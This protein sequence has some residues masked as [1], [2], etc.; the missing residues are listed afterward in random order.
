MADTGARPLVLLDV[1]GPLN[2]YAAK[3]EKRP[4]GYTTHW[5]KP[6]SWVASNPH[7]RP[8]PAAYTRPLRLW[9][10]PDHGSWL[11]SLGGDL[12]WASTWMHEANEFIG[13]RIG[14]PHLPVIEWRRMDRFDP[15]GL[16]WKTRE[17]L[18][19]V[20]DGR[21]FVWIDDEITDA[22]RAWV[23]GNHAG[24]ALLHRV[25]PAIG[26]T[27]EDIDAVAAWVS[28]AFGGRASAAAAG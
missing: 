1:D 28:A 17:I 7:G 15:D 21:S 20:G 4:A 11:R 12:V 14:L 9:L 5:V 6:A 19:W 25:H 18:D 22:D 2:P 27:R 13:P 26:L 16:H 3:P 8:R 10:N 23:A 24:P